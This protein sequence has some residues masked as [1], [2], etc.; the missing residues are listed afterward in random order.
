LNH[1]RLE[2][3]KLKKVVLG[4]FFVVTVAS[5]FLIFSFGNEEDKVALA[6][7]EKPLTAEETNVPKYD[8]FGRTEGLREFIDDQFVYFDSIVYS[9]KLDSPEIQSELKKRAQQFEDVLPENYNENAPMV[10]KFLEFKSN[11]EN[12]KILEVYE[13][14]GRLNGNLDNGFY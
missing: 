8:P 13:N 2:S 1:N 10:K 5:S 7:G 3:F 12:G 9:D 14:L 11:I 6:V 4:S